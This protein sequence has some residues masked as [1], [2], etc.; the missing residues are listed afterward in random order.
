VSDSRSWALIPTEVFARAFFA[1]FACRQ[2]SFNALEQQRSSSAMRRWLGGWRLPCADE[3]GYV[4]ERIELD[5]LRECLGHIHSRLKR[6]KVLSP[7]HGWM[8]AAID[9]HETHS[10]YK[11]CCDRCLQR[12]VAAGSSTRTQYYHRI[13][14]L[15]I[16]SEGFRF[17]LD[18]E[19]V[20]PGEDEV[21]AALRLV[22]RVLDNH[23]RCFDVLTCDAI[24]LR[25][26]M[27]DVL[28]GRGKHLVTTLKANQPE[29]LD[30]A[31]RLL[32]AEAPEEFRKAKRGCPAR[33]VELRQAEGFTT[34]TIATPL[35]VVHAHETGVKRERV[36]HEWKITPVDSTWY[37]ATTMP[38]SL[39]TGRAVFDF[40]HDRWKIENEGFNELRTHW[41]SGHVFHH[42]PN[43]ILVLWLMLF[44]AHAVFHCFHSRNLKPAVRNGRTTIYF[45]RLLDADLRVADW[46]PPPPG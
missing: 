8:L 34:A 35:R 7:S 13:V 32:P 24:Y 10:S 20:L 23:P 45:A 6:N 15:Q 17:H 3:L 27:I 19:P 21:A 39:A 31:R 41:N 5:G 33:S 46:W 44:M 12:Q 2:P 9:G 14:A 16:I 29:L 18:L 37:W 43:S 38:T 25:P 40:G 36:A 22:A 1:M 42:H 4:S 11:R 26:S 30:E 28:L